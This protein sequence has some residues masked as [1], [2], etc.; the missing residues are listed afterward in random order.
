MEIQR[1]N[2]SNNTS[3]SKPKLVMV[4]REK[5][6]PDLAKKRNKA[7]LRNASDQNDM[8]DRTWRRA[9]TMALGL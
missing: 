3:P 8:T 2:P 5:S 1:W 9:E 4:P 7:K 6:G